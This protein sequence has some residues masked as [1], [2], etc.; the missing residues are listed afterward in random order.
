M[1]RR[2]LPARQNEVYVTK[3]SRREREQRARETGRVKEIEAAW[4]A[5][6]PAD[7]AKAF[8]A[9]VEAARARGPLPPPPDMAP[10]TL[11]NPPRREPR[12]TKT[13]ERPRRGR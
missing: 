8:A 13:E 2:P 7:V 9:S 6:V 12:P 1:G 11:P 5:S 3:R 10:G 4:A